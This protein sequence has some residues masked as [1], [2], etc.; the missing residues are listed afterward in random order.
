MT[1]WKFEYRAPI[2]CCRYE[3]MSWFN[4]AKKL[5][6]TQALR[7]DYKSATDCG[8]HSEYFSSIFQI[9][10]GNVKRQKKITKNR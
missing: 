2:L 6:N 7:V 5:S 8:I 4:V 3:W 9:L 1:A 10:K